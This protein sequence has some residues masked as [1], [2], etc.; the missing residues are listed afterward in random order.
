MLLQLGRKAVRA[1]LVDQA[2]F[3]ADAP[4]LSDDQR[5]AAPWLALVG[6]RQ[7]LARPALIDA[8]E[9]PERARRA[10]GASGG[11]PLLFR[12]FF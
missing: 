6:A 4:N 5:G 11:Q 1:D 2:G 3:A 12:L 7:R 9:F 8:R 10:S